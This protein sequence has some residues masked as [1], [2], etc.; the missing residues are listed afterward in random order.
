MAGHSG[1]GLGAADAERLRRHVAQER[2]ARA[3][4]ARRR[5]IRRSGE[6]HLLLAALAGNGAIAR[7]LRELVSRTSLII[8]VYEAPGASCCPVDE[9]AAIIEAL[10]RRQPEI[11]ARTMHAHL[12]GI[13]Q[14]L[15]L[16]R[17]PER[18]VDLQ[19][20]LAAGRRAVTDRRRGTV[21]GSR[22]AR[23]ANALAP[24]E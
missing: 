1:H 23:T 16:D 3:A 13:E 24:G 9:H 12:V 2:Q 11:A 17:L 20:V 22:R 5:L 8:A 10:T 6:F 14:R 21:L 19:E 7:F 18:T 4:G 15:R